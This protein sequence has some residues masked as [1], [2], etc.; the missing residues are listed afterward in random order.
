MRKPKETSQVWSVNLTMTL[1][2]EK[3]EVKH[4]IDLGGDA[5]TVLQAIYAC[6]QEVDDAVTQAAKS[7]VA[8][9][10]GF[11]MKRGGK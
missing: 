9:A 4:D 10:R 7:I 3:T 1:G 8:S 5:R 2:D 11:G 6:A